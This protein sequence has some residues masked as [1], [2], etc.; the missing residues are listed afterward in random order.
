[1]AGARRS[2]AEAVAVT[3]SADG[4]AIPSILV[5]MGVSGSGK[6]TIAA[7][8]AR[9]LGW[10]FRDADEFHPKSNIAKMKSG[11]ALTDADR[12]PWLHAIA[13]FIDE[14]RAR[15]DH[16]IV[17]CSALKRSYRDVIVGTRQD[18]RLIYLKGDITLIAARLRA[19]HGHFMPAALLQSQFD[20]LE[21]PGADE[22]PLT[23]I[24]EGTPQEIAEEVI[25]R[26]GLVALS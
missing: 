21:E 23:V 4:E 17:T 2:S 14:K 7:L 20:A 5:V 16:A 3:F 26:L 24:V 11:V 12:W 1:M 18:V 8:L 25:E 10:T 9:K 13:S 15:S 19:R 6:T 22:N